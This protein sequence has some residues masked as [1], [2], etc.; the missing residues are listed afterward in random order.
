MVI[1]TDYKRLF[2]YPDDDKEDFEIWERNII[3]LLEITLNWDK[4]EFKGGNE[5]E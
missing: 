4:R 1:K 5:I 3:D 2:F